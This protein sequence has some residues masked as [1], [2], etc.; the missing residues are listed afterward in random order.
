MDRGC[1]RWGLLGVLVLFCG[2]L[3][4]GCFSPA[5]AAEFEF[6]DSDCPPCG[7]WGE[8]FYVENYYD[9]Y[10]GRSFFGGNY[11]GGLFR[12]SAYDDAADA[13]AEFDKQRNSAL[14]YASGNPA[15]E[16]VENSGTR[17]LYVREGTN[18]LGQNYYDSKVYRLYSDTVLIE[19]HNFYPI[20]DPDQ[21]VYASSRSVALKNTEALESCAVSV[22]DGK[23]GGVSFAS[24]GRAP[25]GE[26]AALTAGGIGALIF[27]W[28]L[29]NGAGPEFTEFLRETI[30]GLRRKRIVDED[31][32]VLYDGAEPEE[33]PEDP[34]EEAPP[35][36]ADAVE[37]PGEDEEPEPSEEKK[38][39]VRFCTQC[40]AA[41]QPGDI[42]CR[43]CGNP[44]RD[45]GD[46]A[47][48]DEVAK[49]REAEGYIYDPAT[50][51]W[52]KPPVTVKPLEHKAIELRS[53][54]PGD[55]SAS[56]QWAESEE[57]NL[58][59]ASAT[60]PLVNAVD[61]YKIEAHRTEVLNRLYDEAIAERERVVELLRE[62]RAKGEDPSENP[63]VAYL[64]GQKAIADENI[65]KIQI[66]R[67]NAVQNLQRH[68]DRIVAKGV[69]ASMGIGMHAGMEIG[70]GR[71]VAGVGKATTNLYVNWSAGNLPWQHA[72][73]MSM[74]GIGKD[75]PVDAHGFDG[76]TKGVNT[77][78][79]EQQLANIA[80]GGR[81]VQKWFEATESGASPEAKEDL[82]KQIQQH[83]DAKMHLKN[84]PEEIQQRFI[85][86]VARVNKR[87]D[88]AFIDEL[89]RRGYSLEPEGGTARPVSLA[90]IDEVRNPTSTSVNMDRDVIWKGKIL[91]KNGKAISLEE[92]QGIY[93]GAAR[94]HGIDARTAMHTVT[95]PEKG[96]MSP[97]AYR[98]RSGM[99]PSEF[100][101]PETIRDWD[102]YE[103]E[104]SSKV[105]N[106]KV[107]EN[108]QNLDHLRAVQESCRG[109]AKDARKLAVLL[110]ER[111]A[112]LDTDLETALGIIKKVG[113]TQEG[114]TVAV[115]EAEIKQKTGMSLME[116][117]D[118]L[119]KL[120]EATVKL[121]GR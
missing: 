46:D 111:G 30:S 67:D 120:H 1:V 118:R 65:K 71:A 38:P 53:A 66:A 69:G 15:Y 9:E 60:A 81:L 42:F 31:G 62:A 101:D 50:E 25:S 79:H 94:S 8:P 23:T 63:L 2:A 27:V 43:R 22:L 18:S 103:G 37:E 56:R 100:L 6:S 96:S 49:R 116:A 107:Y 70:A 39:G 113:T 52:F 21:I 105:S 35:D 110:D 87:I 59:Y 80:E 83:Y 84:A 117:C 97:E 75:V 61:E 68:G 98:V 28:L 112:R 108:T 48:A 90:D 16:V 86:D 64:E 44:L 51:T 29:T 77:A 74:G 58:D 3:C 93:N 104:A 4:S 57:G 12:I 109:T 36:E 47:F 26:E 102:G 11:E 32:T 91:D 13:R 95:G 33:M 115:G 85:A 7:G 121:G 55:K 34:G 82:V 24:S 10:N 106:W 119:N 76:I 40:G 20:L 99:K 17:I 19:A 45:P 5:T 14:G 54:T 73:R 72:S 89:N 78:M 114:Y 88:A 41:L 92:A